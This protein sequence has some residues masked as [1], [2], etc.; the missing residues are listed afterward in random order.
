MTL[1][2]TARSPVHVVMWL[3]RLPVG[4]HGLPTPVLHLP[5]LGHIF[6][7]FLASEGSRSL[8]AIR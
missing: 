3:Q 8:N 5:T 6:A 1:G 7:T 2:F 4:T